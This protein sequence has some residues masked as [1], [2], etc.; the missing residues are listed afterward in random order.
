MK[1]QVEIL[2][3]NERTGK[4]SILTKYKVTL[5]S[6]NI[7]VQTSINILILNAK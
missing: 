5:H 1:K 4:L 2:S 6:S 7:F 3:R